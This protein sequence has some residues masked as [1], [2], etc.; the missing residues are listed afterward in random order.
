VATRWSPSILKNGTDGLGGDV[1]V[2]AAEKSFATR[3]PIRPG[4][5]NRIVRVP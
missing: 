2:D 4:P 5:Q 3:S 1:D